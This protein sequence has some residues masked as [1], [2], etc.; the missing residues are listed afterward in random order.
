[1]AAS[2]PFDP[3]PMPRPDRL[4]P[5][6]CMV[7]AQQSRDKGQSVIYASRQ[8]SPHVFWYFDTVRSRLIRSETYRLIEEWRR[9]RTPISG[10]GVAGNGAAER[11]LLL[12]DCLLLMIDCLLLVIDCLLLMIDVLLRPESSSF[13]SR[14]P[15]DEATVHFAWYQN[16]DK[17][18]KKCYLLQLPQRLILTNINKNPCIHTHQVTVHPCDGFKMS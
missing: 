8:C 2:I 13:S 17:E 14:G 7:F 15:V 18:I 9:W 11:P 12:F 16:T 3:P 5:P 6:S 4:L 10:H 1:M